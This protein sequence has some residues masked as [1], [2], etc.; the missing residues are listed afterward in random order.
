MGQPTDS[1][2]RKN[3]LK[4]PPSVCPLKGR[5]PGFVGYLV[6]GF[7]N[8]ATHFSQ[9][10]KTESFESTRHS[11]PLRRGPRELRQLP[12]HAATQKAAAG[13]QR[14]SI[15]HWDMAGARKGTREPL[16][17]TNFHRN[18]GTPPQFTLCFHYILC[19]CIY[20]IYRYEPVVGREMIGTRP[21]FA[22]VPASFQSS[23]RASAIFEL[24]FATTAACKVR[25]LPGNL[26]RTT[27]C[28]EV[29]QP[30]VRRGF[31]CLK[32]RQLQSWRNTEF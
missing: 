22:R 21:L 2:C 11:A 25:R 28:C 24:P 1:T 32:S 17:S 8:P 15:W 13:D 18:K 6:W 26:L 23:T 5:C 9:I 27:C 16:V 29:D 7:L 12:E 10:Q 19:I 31:T 30:K 4:R 20:I 3:L 14:R